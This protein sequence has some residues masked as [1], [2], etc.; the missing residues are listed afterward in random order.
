MSNFEQEAYHDKVNSRF[1]NQMYKK[2]VTKRYGI[3][4]CCEEDDERVIIQQ[5]LVKKELLDLNAI[6]DPLC[7]D[8]EPNPKLGPI[9]FLCEQITISCLANG[10]GGSF[11]YT[12]CNSTLE[13]NISVAV[14]IAHTEDICYN[15]SLPHTAAEDTT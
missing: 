11:T 13:V 1:A 12:P 6:I 10:Y 15:S 5:D 8:G 9:G 4:F 3:E 14:R 2:M 7:I